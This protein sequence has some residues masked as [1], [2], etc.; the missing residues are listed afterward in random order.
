M[1]TLLL[2]GAWVLLSAGLA[3]TVGRL[4]RERDQH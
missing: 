2:V 1:L 3:P 4:I